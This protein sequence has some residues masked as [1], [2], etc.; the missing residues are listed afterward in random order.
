MGIIEETIKQLG[1]ERASKTE[2]VVK[3]LV[4]IGIDPKKCFF[5]QDD[6][7]TVPFS[8]IPTPRIANRKFIEEVIDLHDNF[9]KDVEQILFSL[10]L[11]YE[12]PED[13]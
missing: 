2:K 11:P 3:A 4:G 8:A 9:N 13:E 1:W 10:D 5:D 6:N 7:L 12:E